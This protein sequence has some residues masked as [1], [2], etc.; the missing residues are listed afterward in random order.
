MHAAETHRAPVMAGRFY[1]ADPAACRRDAERLC[2]E[3]VVLPADLPDILHAAVV[4]HAGWVCSGRIAALALRVLQQRTVAKTLLITGSVHTM[5]LR[6]PALDQATQWD[7]PLG[8]V[9]VDTDLRQALTALDAFD[10][11][12]PAHRFEHSV[13]VQLP[14][15]QALWG[16]SVRIVPCMI[17][18]DGRAAQW[19]EQLGSLL[20]DWPLPVAIVCSVDLTHY[21]PNYHFTPAGLGEEGC[22][23]AHQENDKRLLTMMQ[24]LEASQVVE[25]TRSHHNSCGGG[26]IAATLAACRT[27]GASRGWILEHSDSARELLRLGHHDRDNSV[28]Y[29]GVVFG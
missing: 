18:P 23:W 20:A 5:D 11:N 26:A 6:S 24:K 2:A 14:F 25:E 21:G 22:R 1:Q 13:E 12:D 16:A 17:P 28:G 4:P 19:G 7:T 15:V 3:P 29:A 27:L 8:S 10:V 9:P